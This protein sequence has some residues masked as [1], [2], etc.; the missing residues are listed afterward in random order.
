MPKK[1]YQTLEANLQQFI[2]TTS[3]ELRDPIRLI[4]NSCESSPAEQDIAFIKQQAQLLLERVDL[5]KEI[6]ALSI[7]PLKQEEV[8]AHDVLMDVLF[9]KKAVIEAA[10]ASITHDELPSLTADKKQLHRLMAEL[11]QNAI[12]AANTEPPSV[13]ISAKKHENM[14]K[15]SVKDNGK[16][17]D[18]AYFSII[19]I[20]FQKLDNQSPKHG[21]GLTFAKTVVENQ[22][23]VIW[24]ES[25]ENKGTTCFFKLPVT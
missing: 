1:D 11:I 18:E 13:H 21:A 25:E 20:L 5:I 19:F 6:Y 7:L 23:G 15:F 17:M 8:S 3:H 9:E 4:I 10:Q 14:W 16:G 12:D 2:Q 24:M 22:G